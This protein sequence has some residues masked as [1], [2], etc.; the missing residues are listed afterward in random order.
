MASKICTPAQNAKI[1]PLSYEHMEQVI[2]LLQH[3]SVFQPSRDNYG[4]IW[5]AFSA[6]SHVFSVVATISETVIGYGSV[7]IESKIRGGKM[8]HIEDIVTS[9]SVRRQ[10]IGKSIIAVLLDIAR[11]HGCYKV[12]LQCQQQNVAFYAK[13]GFQLSGITM[14]KFASA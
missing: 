8:G 5:A 11:Q 4:D 9:P 1:M 7:V 6:Q 2:A 3:I 10:G 13:C 12:A 14:Q